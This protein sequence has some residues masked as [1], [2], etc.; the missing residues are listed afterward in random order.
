M[1]CG[2]GCATPHTCEKT[3]CQLMRDP[4]HMAEKVL[5]QKMIATRQG[6]QKKRVIKIGATGKKRK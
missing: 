2:H 1:S 5:D 3:G 6:I 4:R